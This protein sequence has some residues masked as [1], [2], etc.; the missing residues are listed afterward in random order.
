MMRRNGSHQMKNQKSRLS[1]ISVKAILAI[2]VVGVW[3]W[4]KW[5]QWTAVAFAKALSERR[6]SDAKK[7]LHGTQNEFE[8]AS[9]NPQFW[10][11][12]PIPGERS[13]QDVI[14]GRQQFNA[15]FHSMNNFEV[16][17]GKVVWCCSRASVPVDPI[18]QFTRQ[19]R[20]A[21]AA[22]T[23]KQR[24]TSTVNDLLLEHQN[25]K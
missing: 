12:I 7:L 25:G 4:V 15:T 23:L 10:A 14:L 13:W 11:R 19:K 24:G 20:K 2:F 8:F 21:E 22:E 3:C 5:P 1:E 16:V 17:R 9:Q 6:T 18:Y